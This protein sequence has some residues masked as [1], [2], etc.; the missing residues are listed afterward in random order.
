MDCGG[1]YVAKISQ[2]QSLFAMLFTAFQSECG[3]ETGHRI[4]LQKNILKIQYV[5][6][7]DIRASH[8]TD[9]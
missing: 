9:Y 1:K 5:N 8:L 3:L 2:F 4:C 6:I 7:T